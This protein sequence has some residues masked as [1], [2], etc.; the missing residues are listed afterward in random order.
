MIVNASEAAAEYERERTPLYLNR[1]TLPVA[2]PVG[3]ELQL[4]HVLVHVHPLGGAI[5]SA[6]EAAVFAWLK[7]A[8]DVA[9]PRDA[10]GGLFMHL[11]RART[12]KY[13]DDVSATLHVYVPVL[14]DGGGCAAAVTHRG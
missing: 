5:T 1:G 7:Q 6:C 9:M 13:H 3:C 12:L 10:G 4:R 8:Y 14:R 11:W 2:L